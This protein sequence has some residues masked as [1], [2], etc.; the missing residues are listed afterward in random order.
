VWRSAALN[1][2]YMTTTSLAYVKP[3]LYNYWNNR[4]LP[5]GIYLFL[6]DFSD[7]KS[8]NSRIRDALCTIK[9][10]GSRRVC[11]HAFLAAVVR[12]LRNFLFRTLLH[13]VFP[14]HIASIL[15]RFEDFLIVKCIL[16]GAA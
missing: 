1:A 13:V 7:K 12:I 4:R 16:I 14:L 11:Y 5:A 8:R 3:R 6:S 2:S 15:G 10:F 9:L